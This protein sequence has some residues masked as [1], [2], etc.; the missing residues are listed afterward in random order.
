MA[1][2]AIYNKIYG[3][4][5]HPTDL[6]TAIIILKQPDQ[7]LNRKKRDVYRVGSHGNSLYLDLCDDAGNVVEITE[8]RLEG[9]SDP[10][11]YFIREKME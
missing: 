11:V 9:Y 2:N 4:I 10:P 6:N 8:K 3:K 5:H 7:A 1:D